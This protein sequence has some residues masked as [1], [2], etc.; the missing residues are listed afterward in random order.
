MR[1]DHYA[2]FRPHTLLLII[3]LIADRT[4]GEKQTNKRSGA[5]SGSMKN[6]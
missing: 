4:D 3:L 6:D 2:I 5:S 1:G